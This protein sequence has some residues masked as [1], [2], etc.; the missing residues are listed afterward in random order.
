MV[1]KFY[2][3]KKGNYGSITGH[4]WAVVV[5]VV[6]LCVWVCML[7]FCDNQGVATSKVLQQVNFLF[8][9]QHK[10]AVLHI[11]RKG[12]KIGVG[13]KHGLCKC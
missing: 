5:T 11:N 6:F 4:A 7:L 9:I 2:E 12:D 1:S 13:D 3:G 10:G 8:I